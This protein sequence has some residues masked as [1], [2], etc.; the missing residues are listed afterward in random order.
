VAFLPF[1]IPK[2]KRLKVVIVGG[3]YAGMA[4]LTA[5][6]RYAPDTD[7]T[8][9]DPREQHIKI[10][11]LHE[12]FRYPMSDLQVSYADLAK[13]F[14]FRY[15][16]ATLPLEK[17]DLQQWQT[18]KHLVLNEEVLHFDYL[19]ITPGCGNR[20]IESTPAEG[21]LSLQ[22]FMTNSGPNLLNKFLTQQDNGSE[23]IVT[24]VGGGA[25][26]IQFLFEIKQFLHRQRIK[27][28]LRLIHSNER[29]LEQFPL[30]FHTYV[31]S[32]LRDLDIEF[33]PNTYYQSQQNN[34]VFLQDKQTKKAF[35]LPSDL[36]LLFLGKKQENLYE[37]N[38]FGQVLIDH[39]SLANIFVAGDCSHYNS[40]GSNSLSAQSAVRKGKLV[41][42]NI[43][44]HSSVF[45]LLEPYL[46][47]ELGYVV[48][49]G[50]ADAVG[51]LASEGNVISGLPALAIKELVESQ[52]DL[53]LMGIDTYLV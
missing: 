33:Y 39:K 31:E 28:K 3:G 34:K 13:R 12:S 9:I 37:A 10:T 40:I 50:H 42:R 23:Q 35:E 53:L 22:D 27:S 44:R 24:V 51:W 5:L 11:H 26:G 36:S 47:H 8:L 15:I 45:N 20:G 30:G 4:A 18:D 19:L 17:E 7:I 16:Q 38:C 41:A 32:R 1:Y 14:D 48:S 49:L 2:Q 29:L 46:H 6:L 43:L 21:V 52:Y 25:T